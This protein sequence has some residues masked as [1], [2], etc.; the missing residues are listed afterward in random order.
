[1]LH[2]DNPIRVANGQRTS[3]R[4]AVSSVVCMSVAAI[5]ELLGGLRNWRVWHLLG[6]LELRH[7]YAR[8]KLGQAWLMLSTA[9]MI[10]AL[11]SIWSILWQQPIREL[12]P[13]IGVGLI[14]WTYLA[15]VLND[16]T[17]AFITHSHLYRNQKMNLSVSIYSVIY[18]NSLILA[19]NLVIV[20]VL[21]VGFGV[22]I[23]W[24]LLQV[25]PAF[26]LTWVTMLW[27]G[28]VTGMLCARYR[29][30]IQIVT[31]WLTV[32]F[33]ITPV[34]WKPD[35]LPPSYRFLVDFNP[36]AQYLEVLRNPFLGLPV[37]L[38][39]WCFITL[40]AFGGGLLALPVIGRYQRRIIFWM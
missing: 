1:M 16:S 38:G 11:G 36:L 13:F 9:V 39:T 24:Y 22:P 4:G 18:K 26:L 5:E 17:S 2:R 32:L 33:F 19:H 3:D 12:L 6:T 27:V 28:Y 23:N 15:Q 37:S 40:V 34:M 35:F 14:M 8:S 25:I 10:G 30:V 7:R 20:A 29:D 21:I 31:T